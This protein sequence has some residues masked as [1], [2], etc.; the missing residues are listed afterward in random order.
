MVHA[1]ATDD[2]RVPQPVP[3]EAQ[4]AIDALQV[5]NRYT[6][7]LVVDLEDKFFGL[8][9]IGKQYGASSC[10]KTIGQL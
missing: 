7:R 8:A 3:Q 6:D 9:S 10:P 2:V 4:F 5:F 1:T